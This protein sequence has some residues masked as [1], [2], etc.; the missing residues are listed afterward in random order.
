MMQK[1]TEWKTRNLKCLGINN[2]SRLDGLNVI[3]VI[4]TKEKSP[5]ETLQRLA[6]Y[7]EEQLTEISPKVEMTNRT[8]AMCIYTSETP[9]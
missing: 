3:F 2:L 8:K 5:Q 4:S 1:V 9:F 7:Y 6:S